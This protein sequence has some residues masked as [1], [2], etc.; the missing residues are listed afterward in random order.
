MC[1]VEMKFAFLLTA[2]LS[3]LCAEVMASPIGDIDFDNRPAPMIEP[4]LHLNAESL[5]E[6]LADV[7]P[8]PDVDADPQ[9]LVTTNFDPAIDEG[10]FA[11]DV[12]QSTGYLGVPE[13]PPA[14]LILMGLTS[15]VFFA[16]GRRARRK[17]RRLRRRLVVRMRAITAE[18]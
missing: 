16:L 1:A 6:A 5:D 9:E 3:G 10:H 2:I 15:F 7:V 11:L 8:D 4:D 13:P 18:R 14:T 12:N 17:R